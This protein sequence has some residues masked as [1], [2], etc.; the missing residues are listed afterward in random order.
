MPKPSRKPENPISVAVSSWLTTLPESDQKLNTQELV[1]LAPKRWVV[2]PPM[3]LLPSG[4]FTSGPWPS[5]LASLPSEHT[6]RLWTALLAAVS[7]KT[8]VLTHLAVNEGIPLHLQPPEP[9]AITAEKENILRSPSSLRLLH[10]DFGPSVAENPVPSQ[11]DLDAALWVSTRQNGLTQVWA[12]RWTMFSRGNVKEKARL[13]EQFPPS[14]SDKSKWAVDLYAGIGYFVFSYARL[15]LRVLCWELNPW[16]VEGL[17]R[18]ARANGFSVRVVTDL[19]SS[20][21]GFAEWDEQIIVFLQD[22]A[23]AAPTVQSVRAAG[24][25]LEV[26]HVNCGF[27]PSS[28]GSWRAAWEIQ[29]GSGHDGWLHLHENVGVA[30]IERRRGEIQGLVDRWCD[31]PTGEARVEH[32]ERVKTFAPGVW[33]CVFDVYAG[34]KKP[35]S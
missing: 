7:T 33:H 20:P 26:V 30:D 12:P 2:Y 18:G 31:G 10:G 23:H 14:P 25:K 15:G 32:V 27:L 13:L 3:L 34:G 19:L 24:V 1:S 35:P 9:E 29:R 5:L 21:N 28:S 8:V 16:S 22:N 4:S 6:A 11:A 17:V